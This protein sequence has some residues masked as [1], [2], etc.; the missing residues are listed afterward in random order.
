MR[1]LEKKGISPVVAT[2]LLIAIAIILVLIVFTWAKTWVTEKVTKDLGGGGE[3]IEN[4]CKDIEIS[5]EI[6][7]TND[8]VNVNNK[9]NIPLYGIEIRKKG[10]GSISN[11]GAGYFN[12]GL[13]KGSGKSVN[14]NLG[15]LN[16]GDEIIIVPILLGETDSYRKPYTCDEEFGENLII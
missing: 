8:K 12:N 14:I 1:S 3:V 4:F 10:F 11:I 6:D 15:S 9:G 16:I 2:V 5:A 13:V 7:L